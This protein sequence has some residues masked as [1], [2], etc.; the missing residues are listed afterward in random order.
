MKVVSLIK[1][2][3]FLGVLFVFLGTYF[4]TVKVFADE[5][6]VIS[7]TQIMSEA[8]RNSLIR[9]IGHDP[10]QDENLVPI[11]EPKIGQVIRLH[12]KDNIEWFSYGNVIAIQKAI[13][14]GELN[15]TDYYEVLFSVVDRMVLFVVIKSKNEYFAIGLHLS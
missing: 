10:D 11:T 13:R 6:F 2:N 15:V 4:Q 14:L 5:F 1:E 3:L 12:K 7:N 8:P 9:T